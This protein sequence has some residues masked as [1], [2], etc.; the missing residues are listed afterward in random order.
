MSQNE[1][2]NELLVLATKRFRVAPGALGPD[3]DFYSALGINSIEALELL[4]EIELAFDVEIPDYELQE[5]RTF[6][7]LA[8]KIG[9]RRP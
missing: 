5:V 6:N 8:E 1:T 3:D 9:E 2:A 7:Q 4:S